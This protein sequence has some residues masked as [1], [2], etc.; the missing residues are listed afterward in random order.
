M[1]SE[2]IYDRLTRHRR[3]PI[4]TLT[5]V[6]CCFGVGAG[7]NLPSFIAHCEL[8][9]LIKHRILHVAP[10]ACWILSVFTIASCA[11]FFGIVDQT[12]HAAKR[13]LCTKLR[14]SRTCPLH[15]A[16]HLLPIAL[17]WL[18]LFIKHDILHAPFCALGSLL[19]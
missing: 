7:G 5:V 19:R 16:C 14:L 4:Q 13:M 3:E 17:C 1:N 2:N 9:L 6:L 11:I 12:P 8:A 18:V 10:G 15:N